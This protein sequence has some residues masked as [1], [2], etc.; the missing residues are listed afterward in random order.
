MKILVLGASGFIGTNLVNRLKKEGHTVG[1]VDIELPRYVL[2]A[3]D[4]KQGDLRD[5]EFCEKVFTFPFDRVYQLAADMGGAG[6]IFTG[7]HDADIMYNSAQIN[8]NAAHYAQKSGVKQLFYSS[9]ACV[10]RDLDTS[11]ENANPD[12]DYGWEKLFSEKLYLAYHRNYGLNVRIARFHNIFGPNGTW[13][14]GKEKSPAAICRKVIQ[15]TNYIELWGDGTQTR[16]YLYIDECLDA[17]ERL[18]QSDFIGPVN[19]GSSE[20]ISI[21]QLAKMAMEFRGKNLGITY[22]KGPVGVQ[23][24]TSNNELIKEKLGWKPSHLL[25]DGL[26]KLYTWIQGQNSQS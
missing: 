1:G 21:E 3:D 16:S 18:M 24:R 6:Y 9:S 25:K 13:D 7:E 26:L 14:G 15:A 20:R 22:I 5:Q 4:F 2:M 23:A 19:I 11:E 10:Y 8:L 12:S 17:I